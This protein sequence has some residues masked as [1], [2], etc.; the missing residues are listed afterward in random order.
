MSTIAARR[1]GKELK[2]IHGEGCPVGAFSKPHLKRSQT[3]PY[4]N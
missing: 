3:D 2:E 4:R 1:L